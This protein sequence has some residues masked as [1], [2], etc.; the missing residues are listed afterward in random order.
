[1]SEDDCEALIPFAS[2]YHARGSREGRIQ[3]AMKENVIDFERVIHAMER[4]NYPGYV[5]VEYVWQPWEHCDEVDNLSETV[6]LRDK[7][8]AAAANGG[9]K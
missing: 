3:A 5:G 6:M 7:L 2:H 4:A 9:N 1:M 8:R